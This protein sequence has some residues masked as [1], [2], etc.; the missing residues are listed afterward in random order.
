M[1]KRGKGSGYE[2]QLCKEFS[3]WWT[4]DKRD[5]VFWRTS[6]S[7]ARATVRNKSKKKTFGQAGDMQAT[8]PIGQPL[9]DLCTIE[10]KRGYNS[11]PFSNMIEETAKATSN[12]QQMYHEFIEQALL[13]SEAAGTFYWLLITKRDQRDAIIVMPYDLADKL[14]QQGS[15]I[16]KTVP[17]FIFHCTIGKSDIKHKVFGIKL[18]DFFTTVTPRQIKNVL[19]LFIKPC[20]KCGG[21]ML[22]DSDSNM[23]VCNDCGNIG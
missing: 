1:A 6:G 9:I 3:L 13:S 18:E 12:T 15:A 10:I 20:S 23:Y 11:H 8:N 19:T 4:Y 21:K 2:R 22:Y 7:G 17:R 16:F 5:D 14:K